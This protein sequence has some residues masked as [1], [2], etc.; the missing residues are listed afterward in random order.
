MDCHANMLLPLEKGNHMLSRREVGIGKCYVKDNVHAVREVIA[1][2]YHRKVVYNT[3]DL[4]TGKLLCAP[5][6]ICSR[7]QLV[8]WA[9]REATREE[10]AKLIHDEVTELFEAGENRISMNN[11]VV[12]SRKFRSMTEARIL[13]PPR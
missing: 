12:E 4:R 13:T 6:Q 11:P 7:S 10:S 2:L 9:D 5:Q 1:E 3:Y 8:R